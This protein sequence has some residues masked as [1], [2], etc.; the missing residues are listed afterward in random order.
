MAKPA[1]LRKISVWVVA[2]LAVV[3][4]VLVGF[5]PKP[6]VRP[7]ANQHKQRAP[8]AEPMV[9]IVPATLYF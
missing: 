6:D 7:P 8:A 9:E 1:Y 3:G 2:V 5:G 4:V